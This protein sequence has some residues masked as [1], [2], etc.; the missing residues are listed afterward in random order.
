MPITRGIIPGVFIFASLAAGIVADRGTLLV[1]NDGRLLFIGTDVPQQDL[2]DSII[3]A[4]LSRDG[5]KVAFTQI[6]S[7]KVLPN[8]SQIL[9]VMPVRGGTAK[10][11]SQLSA[12]AHFGSIGWMPDGNGIVYEGKDGHLFIATLSGSSPVSRDLGPWY[13][14]FS[15]S[16]DGS[17]I[18][19]AVNSPA[20][21]LEALDVASGQR[22][23]TH[24]AAKVVWDAKFSPDG[25]WIAYEMTLRD[26]PHSKDD[27]PDCTPPTIG[28]RLYSVRTKSD[29]AVS[30]GAAPKDWSNV[31]S[32][33]WSPD[34]KWLALTLGTTDCDYP[35][36]ANGVFITSVDL[37]SQIRASI[38]DMSFEPVFSPDGSAVA[39]VDFSDSPARLIRYDMATRARTLIQRASESHNYYRILDWK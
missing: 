34:S 18:L 12:G 6:E 21:G 39:F 17:K 33:T 37:K 15:V 35:G 3:T 2:G 38:N 22:T 23:L 20:T 1:E 5:Q 11:I 25:E 8:S 10:Q 19:H 16:P 29:S 14:G 13:Q 24:R 28:L 30:I 31:R 9:S 4:V 36:S 7:P 26:P 32:F 27:E